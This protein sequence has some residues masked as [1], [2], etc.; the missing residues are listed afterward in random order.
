MKAIGLTRY[1]PIDDPESLVDIELDK[2]TPGKHDLLVAVK[3][4]AVNPVDTKVRAPKEKREQTPR[5][6]GWDAA[7]VVEA[8]GSDVTLFKVGDEVFYAG[9]I[10]RP[11]S[12]AEFQ[13]VDERIVGSKPQS[14]D[15]SQAAAFPLTAITAYEAFFDRLGIDVNGGNKDETLLIVGGAG[16]VGSIGVQLA[17]IA[18]LQVIA[19]ASRAESIKWVKELGADHAVN[20]HKPLRPQL[21]ALGLKYVDHIALFNNTDQHWDAAVDLIR[22]Q[23]TIVSIVENKG[24]LA[25]EVMK[26]KS[27][28]FAW[29]FM[30]ARS[31]FQTADMNAQ[32]ELLNR[33]AAWIDEGLIKNTASKVLSPIDANN[34][35]SAHKALES[36][37]SIG[38][39]VLEGWV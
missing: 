4:I 14:L 20:H 27:A 21:E 33:V 37:N 10:T 15:F 25:Q 19:T 39:I 13:L 29:E 34:L 24:P 31:M 35:R 9:D 32:H 6:L 16:G 3:A 30:F 12:N 26:T 11:G 17:K 2:P 36:G 1:L 18:G 7:G 28:T 38:K 8:V 22:P 5:V 23:G